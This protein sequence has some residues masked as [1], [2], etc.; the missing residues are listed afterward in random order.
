MMHDTDGL[1]AILENLHLA[2]RKTMSSG[3]PIHAQY[4]GE[5]LQM[6]TQYST[7][8]I[9]NPARKP[10]SLVWRTDRH[11]LHTVS[12]EALSLAKS[13]E[14]QRTL[15]R[16]RFALSTLPG[17]PGGIPMTPPKLPW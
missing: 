4:A 11:T 9:L 7:A 17:E 13:N 14:W 3:I 8:V 2:L 5:L 12:K 16:T 15:E 10:G 1:E 6:A